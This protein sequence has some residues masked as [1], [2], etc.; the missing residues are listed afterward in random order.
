MERKRGVDTWCTPCILLLF[1]PASY[2]ELFHKVRFQSS[3]KCPVGFE[4]ENFHFMC[5]YCLNLSSHSLK[6]GFLLKHIRTV[7]WPNQKQRKSNKVMHCFTSTIR[8][9]WCYHFIDQIN[10]FKII[11][12]NYAAIFFLLNSFLASVWKCF[13]GIFN[14]CKNNAKNRNSLLISLFLWILRNF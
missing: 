1:R 13:T 2:G 9:I 7:P 10:K 11:F 6:S 8:T 4:L 5:L 3:A 12:S 14:C